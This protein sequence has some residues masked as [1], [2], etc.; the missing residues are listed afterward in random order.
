MNKN[1]LK[2]G[3][4]YTEIYKRWTGII[5]RCYNKRSEGYP[6]YGFKG[7]RVC[8]RWHDPAKFFADMGD[9]PTTKHSLRR[10][11]K[12]GNYEPSN[13]YWREQSSKT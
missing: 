11:N 4:S 12:K 2:H 5:N 8:E 7:I 6:R 1:A 10:I 13:C 9:P 3:L